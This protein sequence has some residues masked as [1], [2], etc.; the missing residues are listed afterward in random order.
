MGFLQCLS[1]KFE[2]GNKKKRIKKFHSL[3]NDILRERTVKN[4]IVQHG[5]EEMGNIRKE[6]PQD[7]LLIC[8]IAIFDQC[9]FNGYSAI[10][11]ISNT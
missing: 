10:L 3:L 6:E 8:Y 11:L 9:V 4:P 5:E 7:Q 1:V 2:L